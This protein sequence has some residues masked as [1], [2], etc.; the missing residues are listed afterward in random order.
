MGEQLR[1]T[2]K[3]YP[4]GNF[5]DAFRATFRNVCAD[6]ELP[7]TIDSLD[8]LDPEDVQ[9]LTS[10][11]LSALQVL[12]A[13][14]RLKIGHGTLRGSLIRLVSVST[15]DN[16][17]LDL[18]KPLL[19]AALSNNV[20][21][22]LIWDRVYDAIIDFAPSNQLAPTFIE[23]TPWLRNTSSFANSSEHRKYID[24]VLREELGSLYVG[25]PGFYDTIFGDIPDLEPASKA[26]LQD[27][28]EGSN[29]LFSNGWSEWP[30]EAEQ[31]DVLRWFADFCEKLSAF[32]VRYKPTVTLQRRPISQPNRP[33]DG[34]V[35]QRKM[36]I[37]FVN[38]PRAGKDTKCR[39]DQ[40]LIPGELKKNPSADIALETRLD[41]GRLYSLWTSYEDLEV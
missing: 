26:F 31:D 1:S 12:P 15:S 27:C 23:Q 13:A 38:N 24:D 17:D 22:A 5:L 39:W 9:S 4:I 19:K 29:P 41:L 35:S 7:Q 32:A 28:S 25:L 37:G 30:R 3:E 33:I 10:V 11:L 16:F 2:I 20:D 18:I 21:D 34:S 40:I 36:D 6:R 8:Q 14:K